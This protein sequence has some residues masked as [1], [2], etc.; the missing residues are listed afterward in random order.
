MGRKARYNGLTAQQLGDEL[1]ISAS[2]VRKLYNK[3][4]G[5]FE[6]IREMSQFPGRPGRKTKFAPTL[7]KPI[8]PGF[9][10][11]NMPARGKHVCK[12]DTPDD[13]YKESYYWGDY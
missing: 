2:Q 10:T 12:Y 5:D 8:K 9:Y 3:Y 13:S 1:G 7:G 6:K 4:D 11:F